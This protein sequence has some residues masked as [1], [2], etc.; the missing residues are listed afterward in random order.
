MLYIENRIE[1]RVVLNDFRFGFF[2]LLLTIRLEKNMNLINFSLRFVQIV[3]DSRIL[4]QALLHDGLGHAPASGADV[5]GAVVES[6]QVDDILTIL[7]STESNVENTGL[8]GFRLVEEAGGETIG[9]VERE[10]TDQHGHGWETEN[11][12]FN[13]VDFGLIK[14]KMV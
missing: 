2:Q 14:I 12:K 13:L 10:A 4:I 9:K 3:A 7:L 5:L 1:Q 8:D 11:R 6:N